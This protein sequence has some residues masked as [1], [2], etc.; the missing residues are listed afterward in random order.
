MK[1]LVLLALLVGCTNQNPQAA[2]TAVV[3]HSGIATTAPA[4]PAERPLAAES[5]PPGDIPD[6][7]TFVAYVSPAGGYQIDA[8]EGWGRTLRGSTVS[9]TDK[10]DGMAVTVT[11]ATTGSHLSTPTQAAIASIEKQA[12]AGRDFHISSASLP[13][14]AAV[15]LTFTSNSGADPVTGKRVRLENQAILFEH[16][17]KIASVLLWAPFGADNVDQWK[18]I[19]SSFRWR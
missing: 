5:N 7:Q 8:P 18:R 4:T 17:G 12:R 2:P 15:V 6:S 19:A 3:K 1:R 16:V 11:K 14:G 13:G 10:F 9:F